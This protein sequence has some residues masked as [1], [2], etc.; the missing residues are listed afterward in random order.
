MAI[1][2][3]AATVVAAEAGVSFRGGSG[4]GAAQLSCPGGM[5]RLGHVLNAG[6]SIFDGDPPTSVTIWNTI[7]PDGYLVESVTAGT[8]TGTHLDSP[9][10]FIDGGRTV[11]QLAAEEF[12]WPAYVV[13]VRDRMAHPSPD[14]FQVSA[15][16]LRRYERANGRIP[17]G[18]LVILRTGF[19]ELFGTDAYFGDA[20]GFSGAAVQW[21]VENRGVAAVGSD[22]FGPDATSDSDYL[23]TY[24]ILA[25]DGVA[26]PGLDNLASLSITGDLVMAS[27]VALE[28]GSGYQVDPL[29]CHGA[30][31]SSSSRGDD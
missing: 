26:L 5:S 9:G 19:D 3:T 11:D 21:M 1:A 2:L 12:V 13:D 31:S 4:D 6:A 16:D 17:A 15:A 22:T 14:S 30:R 28:N 7:D 18:A 8:H 20:P 29:A 24:T 10:H 27:A 23:A 25:N